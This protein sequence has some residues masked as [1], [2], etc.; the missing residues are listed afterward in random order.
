MFIAECFMEE[1]ADGLGMPVEKLRE[2]NMYKADE[3]THY[4]QKL[5]D[6]HVPLMWKQVLEGSDYYARKKE[7][8]AFNE[9]SVWKKRGLR[10]IR[11]PTLLPR[12]RL[13]RAT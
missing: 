1:V 2:I 11:C 10:P 8:D 12:L 5:K 3:K 9:R 7:V 6:W 4:L 13:L